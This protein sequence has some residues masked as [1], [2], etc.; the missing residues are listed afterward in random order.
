MLPRNIF[1]PNKS[2]KDTSVKVADEVFIL[3]YVGEG[4]YRQFAVRKREFQ[5]QFVEKCY[6]QACAVAVLKDIQPTM[7][8]VFSGKIFLP[9]LNQIPHFSIA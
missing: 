7:P 6:C 8:K 9:T 3:L 4:N 2:L 1:I 5:N